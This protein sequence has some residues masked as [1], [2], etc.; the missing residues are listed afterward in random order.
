MNVILTLKG[1]YILVEPD[2]FTQL[3]LLDVLFI[4]LNICVCITPEGKTVEVVL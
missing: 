3:I 2:N 4:S 1:Q